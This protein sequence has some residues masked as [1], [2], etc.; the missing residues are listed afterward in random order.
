LFNPVPLQSSD[1]MRVVTPEHSFGTQE[2]VD[3]ITWAVHQVNQRFPNTDQLAVGDISDAD[4]G[5]IKPHKSHQ[6]GRDVDVG[7]YYVD[8]PKWYGKATV[9][10]LDMAR[11]WALID[12][13]YATGML[14]YIFFDAR[15]HGLLRLAAQ[16]AHA[17]PAVETCI[18]DGCTREAGAL[19]RHASGHRTHL[20][21]RF[22]SPRAVEGAAR[23]ARYSG[24]PVAHSATLLAYLQKRSGLTVVAP[25]RAKT[26]H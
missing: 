11:V 1:E 2:T 24:K 15:F 22:L 20:H 19:L 7:L 26:R 21:V 3:S 8:G 18:F 9:F 25:R 12:A 14:E 6:S 23:V 16:A 5:W 4:G 17:D 10:N 13:L